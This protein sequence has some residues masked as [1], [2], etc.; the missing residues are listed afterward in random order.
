MNTKLATT[1]LTV[2]LISLTALCWSNADL[3][4][5][6]NPS[7]VRDNLTFKDFEIVSKTE[8]EV[9]LKSITDNSG[10]EQTTQITATIKGDSILILAT[11]RPNDRNVFI[12]YRV[13][14]KLK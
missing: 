12:N 2:T 8:K 5:R 10:T 7:I 1:F 13:G 14:I 6:A 9:V 4:T 11:L 3:H